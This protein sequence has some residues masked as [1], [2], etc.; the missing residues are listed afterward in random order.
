MTETTNNSVMAVDDTPANLHLLE[1]MLKRGGYKVRLI[2]NGSLA[3]ASALAE[4]PDLILLDVKMPGIDGYEVCTQLKAD[5][6]GTRK[7][8]ITPVS[9]A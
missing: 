2:P 5:A 8:R 9:D 6:L 1:Q 4:P 7:K 3:L